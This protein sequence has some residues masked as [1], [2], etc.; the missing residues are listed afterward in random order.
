[1]WWRWRGCE[2]GGSGCLLA[3]AVVQQRV[4][5]FHQELQRRSSLEHTGLVSRCMPLCITYNQG[6][7]FRG[8]LSGPGGACIMQGVARVAAAGVG[9]AAQQCCVVWNGCRS[10]D[11][12]QWMMGSL[13]LEGLLDGAVQTV[14]VAWLLG[15]VNAG[16]QSHH[17]SGNTQFGLDAPTTHAS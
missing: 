17:V 4:Y 16:S 12:G 2:E 15:R 9:Q 8:P 6:K 3:C 14:L 13:A 5:L 1:V 11:Q 10:A 7:A